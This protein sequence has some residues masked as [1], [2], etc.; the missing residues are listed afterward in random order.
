MEYN[1]AWWEDQNKIGSWG[2]NHGR[3][4]GNSSQHVKVH[5]TLVSTMKSPLPSDL[6]FREMIKSKDREKSNCDLI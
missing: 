2:A 1:D 6:I 3:L 4:T 5:G